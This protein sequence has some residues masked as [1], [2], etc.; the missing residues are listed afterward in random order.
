MVNPFFKNHGPFS[1]LDILKILNI[2]DTVS[3]ENQ[4][5]T[6]IKDLLT[7]KSGEITFFHSQKYKNL[8]KDT[9]ASFCITTKKLI[10]DLPKKTIKIIVNNVLLELSRVTKL[11][12]PYAD[13]DYPDISLKPFT[14]AKYKTVKFGNNVLVGKNVK[15]GK[16]SIIGSNTIIEQNV[17][18]GQECVI[19]KEAFYTEINYLK[20]HGFTIIRLNIPD[21][22]RMER[23]KNTYPTTYE[24]H[25]KGMNHNSEQQINNLN[26]DLDLYYSAGDYNLSLM[27]TINE[28]FQERC[29]INK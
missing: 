2:K 27:K 23:I 5:V 22:I 28:F 6:D 7:S 3:Y 15:I 1:I 26:V 4:D 17:E 16:N 25:F 9:K 13:I 24:E 10:T 18:I 12:Y 20:E 21:D 14:K 19:N 29:L 11:I 8:A